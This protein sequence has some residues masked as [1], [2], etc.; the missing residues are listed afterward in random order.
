ML[1]LLLV[2]AFLMLAGA[3]YSAEKWALLVG[4]NNY[5][6]DIS[7]LRYCVADV[8]AF[9]QALV[10]VAGFKP[11]KVILMT[12]EMTDEMQPIH[13][14]IIMQLEVLANRIQP[15]DTFVFYFSGHGMSRDRRSFL[16]ATN[17][18]TNTE[19]TLEASAVSLDSV[20]RILSRVSAQQLL[21]IIDAC[22]N[23]PISGRGDQDNLLTNDFT[24]GIKIK[25]L[26]NVTGKPN[27]NA[28]LYAC[29]IGERAYEW[30][31]RG[32][33]VFSYY[34]LEGLK[35]GAANNQ[36]EVTVNS[37]AEYTQSKVVEW[38]RDYRD[39]KQTPWLSLEG[40]AKLVLADRVN[41]GRKTRATPTLTTIADPETEMWEIVKDSNEVG[42]INDFLQAFPNG[43][44]AAV[45]QLKLKQLRRRSKPAKPKV[46]RIK[47]ES[48]SQQSTS[49]SASTI[50]GKD[51]AEMVLIP[52]GSFQ[53]GSNDGGDNEKPIHTVYIDAFYMD[54]Y[55]VTN[56]QY[57]KFM[58]ATGHRKPKYWS[59]SR[60]NQPNQPVVGVSWVDAV[61][62]AR[63]AGKRLPTEAEWE[64]AAR[65]G[66]EDKKYPWGNTINSRKARYGQDWGTGKPASVGSYSANGYGLYDMAGNVGEW[67]ADWYDED[68]YSS[69]PSS[70]PQGLS[71]GSYRVLR[72]G[73]W[74]NNAGVLRAAV[75]RSNGPANA[76]DSSGFRCVSGF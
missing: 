15:D 45:A 74:R 55:E 27:V 12:D 14:N 72:G 4:I 62:Y 71:S 31:Q 6:Y 11:D 16:L 19:G 36:G 13:V 35:G 9:R 41:A 67:C 21:T 26:P 65:G 75:R 3:G 10:N 30:P 1:S 61:A 49:T 7:P 73:S 39:R 20:S 56:A 40:G 38:T 32:H 17:S 66:L 23:N 76:D 58:Q 42:D 68:Y 53:M 28:T 18:M 48:F 46:D 24:R 51:G 60:L 52:A 63:W 64:K 5:Q 8:E 29:S 50:I 47:P 33:G 22:R 54:K 69:S 70:N 2:M 57:R 37:L 43:K 25:R 44:L 59:Y 34:L